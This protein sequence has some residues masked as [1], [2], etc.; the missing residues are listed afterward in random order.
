MA[1]AIAKAEREKYEKMWRFESYRERSPGM[2][3]LEDALVRLQPTPGASIIDIGCGSGRVSQAL[4]ERGFMVTAIDIAENSCTEFDGD[5]IAACLWDL[6]RDVGVHD[7]GFCADVMEHIPTKKVSLVLENI[8]KVSKTVY[9]QIA[10]FECHEGDKIGEHLHLTVKPYP[11][12][13]ELLSHYFIVEQSQLNPK[14]HIFVCKS[15]A[16]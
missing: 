7:Y 10:N 3:H 9:F 11:W 13:H 5:F 4:F 12:W 6:P 1:D 14:H 15:L 16:F 2:R 8:S